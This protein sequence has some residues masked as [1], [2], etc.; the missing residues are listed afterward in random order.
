MIYINVPPFPLYLNA[1]NAPNLARKRFEKTNNLGFIT[2]IHMFILH[3]II[4]ETGAKETYDL[5]LIICPVKYLCF[6]QF[7]M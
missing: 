2:T 6:M 3:M 5:L 7:M 4:K 1:E